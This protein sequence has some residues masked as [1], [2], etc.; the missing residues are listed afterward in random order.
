M[1]KPMTSANPNMNTRLSP[2]TDIWELEMLRG[3]VARRIIGAE[4]RAIDSRG[5]YQTIERRETKEIEGVAAANAN[6]LRAY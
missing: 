4:G 6:T 2:T 5:G 1:P 3:Q